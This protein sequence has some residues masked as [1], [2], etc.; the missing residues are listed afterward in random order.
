V[1]AYLLYGG[2]AI[3][4]AWVAGRRSMAAVGLLV[5]AI[6]LRIAFGFLEH[7]VIVFD[8]EEHYLEKAAE[9]DD[10]RIGVEDIKLG[11]THEN[12]WVIITATHHRVFGEALHPMR[13]LNVFLG[14]V[15]ALLMG[16]IAR[17]LR[18]APK[19]EEC[20]YYFGLFGPP[21]LFL[22]CNILK[23]QA[24]AV[25]LGLI[26]CGVL[27]RGQRRVWIFIV[28]LIALWVVRFK[29]MP[30]AIVGILGL[31]IYTHFDVFR[32]ADSRVKWA[33]GVTALAAWIL[34]CT[35]FSDLLIYSPVGKYLT[36]FMGMPSYD[37][38]MQDLPAFH[39]STA[40]VGGWLDRENPVSMRNMAVLSVRNLYSP[41]LCQFIA[42]PSREQGLY[43]FAANIWW[44]VAVPFFAV[45]LLS[46]HGATR[47]HLAVGLVIGTMYLIATA[48]DLTVFQQSWR[49]R[50]AIW[51]VF[52]TVAIMG[53]LEPSGWKRS[54]NLVWWISVMA[55]SAVYFR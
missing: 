30:F 9:I 4:V 14:V 51:P 32:N 2:L 7:S 54:V 38:S 12:H 5:A 8:D 29:L 50:W 31:G 43:W 34:F 52:F 55:F 53:L 6:G 48:T 39:S 16:R 46:T 42:D 1:T 33:V 37:M 47:R 49:Y 25:V 10:A 44:W 19:T 27:E 24:M 45:R 41:G 36:A 28:S 13:A 35:F 26:V 18:A 22:G 3:A 21:M 17:L 23:E 15:M 40:G 11:L 20:V